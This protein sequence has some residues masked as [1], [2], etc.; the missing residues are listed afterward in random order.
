MPTNNKKKKADFSL[1]EGCKVF[2]R[3]KKT[4]EMVSEAQIDNL[5]SIELPNSLN[6]DRNRDLLPF[7]MN[8]AVVNM[9]NRNDDCIDT[10]GALFIKDLFLHKPT[11]LEHKTNKVVG[12]LVAQ[13]WSDFET[14]EILTDEQIKDKKEPFNLVVAGVVYARNNIELAE[15]LINQDD[16][17]SPYYQ[18]I[19]GSW[20]VSIENYDIVI[21]GPLLKDAEIISSPAEKAKY[22]KFLKKKGGPG[23]LPDGRRVGRLIKPEGAIPYGFAFTVN[24]AADVSGVKLFFSQEQV[25]ENDEEED[26][27]EENEEDVEDQ[28]A[29]SGV[30]NKNSS[31]ITD[32]N[33]DNKNIPNEEKNEFGVIEKD[34]NL[35]SMIFKT[36]KEW[37]ASVPAEDADA[38]EAS[39][40]EVI[41]EGIDLAAVAWK[42]KQDESIAALESSNAKIVELSTAVEKNRQE[43]T[44]LYSKL[45]ETHSKLND[46]YS[47]L[48]ANQAE[49]DFQIRMNALTSDYELD[50]AAL[51]VIAKQIKGMNSDDYNEWFVG[52]SVLAK[53]KVKLNTS[54]ASTEESA[55]KEP[56]AK[57]SVAQT[58]EKEIEAVTKA[59]ETATPE[60]TTTNTSEV[61]E[62]L[63]EK[64]GKSFKATVSYRR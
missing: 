14:D 52:F 4:E 55:Q 7:V 45:E 58:Q 30:E 34:L 3:C 54:T 42:Q 25:E 61:K 9:M 5:V 15:I 12:H 2:H 1:F 8:G 10:A 28:E 18:T 29:S 63:S 59:I 62:N 24:P 48:Q 22:V 64:W 60:V 23:K 37:R 16:K 56:D 6:L 17:Q 50:D 51:G 26:E 49:S 27:Y 47:K 35:K 31:L 32:K 11:N 41:K 20:E 46:A 13:A 33:I 39:V 44:E 38:A 21:G 57:A 40:Q 19:C 36:L 43:I 53:A